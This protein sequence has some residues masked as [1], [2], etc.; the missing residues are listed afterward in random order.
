MSNALVPLTPADREA[1]NPR[2]AYRP[3]ADFVAHLIATS[4]QAPQ[5]RQ[6][7]RAAPAEANEIY[8]ARGRLR[9]MAGRTVSLS[10]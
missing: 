6:R 5:T 8:R 10:L 1:A 7:R 9:I 4:A 3:Y 2:A